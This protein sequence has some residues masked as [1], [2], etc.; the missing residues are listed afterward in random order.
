[1]RLAGKSTSTK[2]ASDHEAEIYCQLSVMIAKS[3]QKISELQ[4]NLMPSLHP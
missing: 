3:L 4:I 1:M 2:V